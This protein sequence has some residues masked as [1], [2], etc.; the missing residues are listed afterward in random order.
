MLLLLLFLQ[1]SELDRIARDFEQKRAKAQT[2]EA[3]LQTL[4]DARG[5][6]EAY[7]KRN[8]KE[9]DRAEFMIAEM[10][11]YREDFAGAVTKFDAFVAKYPDV[12]HTAKARFLAAEIQLQMEKDGDASARFADF[13][14]RHP[15]DARVFEARLYLAILLGYARK[16]GEAAAEFEKLR[17]EFKNRR[18]GWTAALQLVVCH[19]LAEKNADAIRALDEV[20][21]GCP[22]SGI[23]STAKRL[24]EEYGRIGRTVEEV[25][26]GKVVVLHFFTPDLAIAAAE[27]QFLKRVRGATIVSVSVDTDEAKLKTF[28]SEMG[29]DWT[30]VR[31]GKPFEGTLAKAHGVRALPWITVFDRKGRARFFNLGGRDLRLA[32]E[33]LSEEK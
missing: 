26:R 8:P 25:P 29:V 17:A 14:K 2:R 7:L 16:F 3:Y 30:V 12:P 13:V 18:E 32:V 11:I 20:I 10:S 6:V 21:A 4:D 22:E 19:H 9:H 1:E 28:T 33:T 5:A 24:R 23:V 27:V 31:D 15:A